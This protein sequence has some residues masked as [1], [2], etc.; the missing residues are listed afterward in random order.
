MKTHCD[1]LIEEVRRAR[2]E[3]SSEFGH[4]IKKAERLPPQRR[5]QTTAAA[6]KLSPYKQGEANDASVRLMLSRRRRFSAQGQFRR[7]HQLVADARA[8]LGLD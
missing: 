4:D 1:P 2:M 8:G 5:T 3:L 7:E 6:G